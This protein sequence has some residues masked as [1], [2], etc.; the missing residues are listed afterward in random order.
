L[1]IKVRKKRPVV[2][3][4]PKIPAPERIPG[5][6]PLQPKYEKPGQ[7]EGTAGVEASKPKLEKVPDLSPHWIQRGEPKEEEKP[8]PNVRNN[9]LAALVAGLIT[10]GV[11]AGVLW[12]QGF[13]GGGGG[14]A[15]SYDGTYSATSTTV[16]P[17]GTHT[18]YGTFTVSNGYVSEGNFNGTVSASGYFTGTMANVSQGS[19]T[20]T[21]TG[22]FSLTST[23]T[24]YGSSGNTSYTI[25]AYKIS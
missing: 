15:A 20:L 10:F 16:T 21:M 18:G 22:Q 5:G 12:S 11:L 14:G 13:F 25:S 7:P 2:T 23:F 9:L 19:P 6:R 8:K 1:K 4:S 24:L 17:S 3:P